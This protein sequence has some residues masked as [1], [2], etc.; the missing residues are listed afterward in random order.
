MYLLIRSQ[1]WDK[2]EWANFE[3]FH[4]YYQKE[5]FSLSAT[6]GQIILKK[7]QPSLDLAST[8]PPL[9]PPP[10]QLTQA[11]RLHTTQSE[12]AILALLAD[13]RAKSGTNFQHGRHSAR[14]SLNVFFLRY[15]TCSAGIFNQPTG[16]RNRV[17]IR[18]SYRPTRLHRLAELIP[19]NRFLSPLKV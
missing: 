13:G 7:P 5:D 12:V 9:H 1:P 15:L 8:H 17:G 3:I 18:L 14:A 2:N 4:T 16:V 10:C 11:E 19:W 6:C